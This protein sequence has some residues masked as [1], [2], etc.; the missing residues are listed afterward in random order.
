MKS[1]LFT[2][3][4]LAATTQSVLSARRTQQSM[5][6]DTVFDAS[7]MSD[8]QMVAFVDNVASRLWGSFIRGWY[9]KSNSSLSIDEQCFGNW[10]VDDMLQ[11]DESLTQL[12]YK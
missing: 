12:L 6:L 10:I 5:S 8:T 11:L 9:S 4:I 1:T 2:A 7:K 3:L